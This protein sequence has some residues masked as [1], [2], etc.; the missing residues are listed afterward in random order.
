M[1]A[2]IETLNY[3]Y[4]D[5]VKSSRPTWARGLKHLGVNT[6]EDMF[7]SRPTW[8]R[9]LK[10]INPKSYLGMSCRAPRGRVD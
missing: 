7:E 4:Y 6:N 9:G 3:D 8:A 2:W 5:V 1:G 10:H